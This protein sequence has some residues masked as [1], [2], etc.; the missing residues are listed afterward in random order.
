MLKWKV[1]IEDHFLIWSIILRV[2]WRG[3]RKLRKRSGQSVSRL[4]FEPST[5]WIRRSSNRPSANFCP[6]DFR[7]CKV[8]YLIYTVEHVSCY[9]IRKRG[10]EM[11]LYSHSDH[12][13]LAGPY[14]YLNVI[15]PFARYRS[16]NGQEK[17][18]LLSPWTKTSR[19]STGRNRHGLG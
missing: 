12:G 17:Q 16:Y 2:A 18:N 13:R 4:R 15:T 14:D 7:S 1:C 6:E 10:F 19:R 3:R 5:S 11:S 9:W 8:S